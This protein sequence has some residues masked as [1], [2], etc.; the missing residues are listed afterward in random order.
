MG[1]A[2]AGGVQGEPCRC[3]HPPL[4]KHRW[5]SHSSHFATGTELGQG[6]ALQHSTSS[7]GLIWGPLS[8]T[9]TTVTPPPCLYQLWRC[10]SPITTASITPCPAPYRV[11]LPPS[12]VCAL[13][14]A[15][16]SGRYSACSCAPRA[17]CPELSPSHPAAAAAAWGHSAR[18][19][20]H[21]PTL[22]LLLRRSLPVPHCHPPFRQ[23]LNKSF[24]QK[25]EPL[26]CGAGRAEA[27]M[28]W[29]W[30]VGAVVLGAVG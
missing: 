16:S 13:I 3:P 5:G 18:R 22:L 1:N 6:T 7:P 4:L 29:R 27:G 20:A 11:A 9:D 15:W 8:L 26:P 14:P 12:A 2:G 10:R 17:L 28:K 19:R 21:P 30:C 23:V 25:V 24:Y